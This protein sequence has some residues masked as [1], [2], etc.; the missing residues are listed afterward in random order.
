[1]GNEKLPGGGVKFWMQGVGTG[2]GVPTLSA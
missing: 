1:M 2:A